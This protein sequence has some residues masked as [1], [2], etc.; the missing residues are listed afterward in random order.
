MKSPG[1]GK[2][3]KKKKSYQLFFQLCAAVLLNGYVLGFKKGKIFTG[4]SKAVCVPVLN[5]YSCPGA[6]GSCPI[7][8]LQAELGRGHFP[9]YVLGTLMMFG[10]LFGRLVCGLIC[11]FG[12][13]QDLLYKIPVRKLRVNKKADRGARSIKYFVLVILV[14]LLP[15]FGADETGIAPPYFCKF[16]CPA[17]TLEGGIPLMIL[18]PQI[19]K[20]A[21]I[22]FDWK[23]LVLAAVVVLST[24]IHRPFCRYLCPLGAFYSLFN[25]YSLYQMRV[26]KDACIGCGKC[27]RVCPMAVQITKN[28]NAAEC[29]RCGRCLTEC[30]AGAIHAGFE[31]SAKGN[32]RD[33]PAHLHK[34]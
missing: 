32:R 18:D 23:V 7:G 11:P 17:G 4:K 2:K 31:G 29:I 9:F 20:L 8:A 28:A 24:L 27:E 3:G 12:L 25:K 10:I 21:G 6:V 16:L 14:L 22:L 33:I 34:E 19:R 13:V 5:C 15:A 30:P 26:D 1:M